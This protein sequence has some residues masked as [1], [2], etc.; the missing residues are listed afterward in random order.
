M[1][2]CLKPAL[3]RA[4]RDRS[5]LQFGVGR[6]HT[7]LLTAAEP[8]EAEFLELLD[9]T[10][11]LPAL[12]DEAA[13]LGIPQERVDSLL[14]ELAASSVLDDTAAQRD[15][16]QLPP[17][18]LARL[19]PDLAALSLAH[20]A[21]GS[22][23]A[24]L[25]ARRRA[26]VQVRGA[27]RVG[28]AIAAVL[29]AAGIGQVEVVDGGRVREQDTSPC[30]LLVGD[31]GRY[32]AA[33][34]RAAV[35]RAAPGR[36]QDRCDS[37]S[38]ERAP[39]LVVVAPRGDSAGLLA[40]PEVGRELL[41]SGIPHLYAG[42]LETLGTVGP[43]VLPG[44]TGCGRCLSLHRADEDPAWPKL[45]AQHCSG[46]G[47]GLGSGGSGGSAPC[48]TALATTVAGLAALHCLMFLDGGSPPS[49][50]GWAEVSMVD[51]SMRRRPLD[52]HPDC[53][54]RWGGQGSEEPKP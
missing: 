44:T 23:P 29:A 40:D 25:L 42:V 28:A 6:A 50:G 27:G 4:W 36:P 31:T 48:D 3:R 41:T 1:R 54:C 53:G 16:L 22:A 24:L 17:P 51:G 34:A 52:P 45:L 15:L 33:A 12:A 8:G 18:E 11:E 10:R 2:P 47:S 35:R 20:P 32:R 49:L 21:P 39:D 38:A 5:T 26:R 7:A 37:G 19:Q 43:F 9:G 30:G 13:G 14:S 46:R